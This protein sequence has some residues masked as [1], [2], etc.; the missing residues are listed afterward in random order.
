M[1]SKLHLMRGSHNTIMNKQWMN[2]S[3]TKHGM[4]K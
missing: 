3:E 2:G 1:N 4:L